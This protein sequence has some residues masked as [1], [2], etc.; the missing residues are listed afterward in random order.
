MQFLIRTA[1]LQGPTGRVRRRLSAAL[2]RW[3]GL[4]PAPLLA[5]DQ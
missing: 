5:G 3:W 1:V 2:G 4:V